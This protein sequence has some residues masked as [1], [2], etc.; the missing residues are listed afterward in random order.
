MDTAEYG[1]KV[2]I[3]L[4][5]KTYEKLKKD[6]R[7]KY[8]RTSVSIIKKMKEDDKITSE[9]YKCLYPTADYIPRIHEH[10]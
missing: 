4:S 3:M 2:T 6:T 10:P 8:K 5:D 9:Q 7:P 1:Q